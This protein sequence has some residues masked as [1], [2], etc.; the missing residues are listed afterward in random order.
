MAQPADDGVVLAKPGI[1]PA[2]H[3][4][5]YVRACP[6]PGR[7]ARP[8]PLGWKTGRWSDWCFRHHL[9]RG[10][11][12]DPES[13]VAYQDLLVDPAFR[14]PQPATRGLLSS[15]PAGDWSAHRRRFGVDGRIGTLCVGGRVAE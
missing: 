7:A 3:S 1:S 12:P 9:Q 11:L 15:F 14:S 6:P 10:G 2:R 5:A 4:A 8:G 13:W